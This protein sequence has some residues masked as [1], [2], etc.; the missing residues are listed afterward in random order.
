MFSYWLGLLAKKDLRSFGDGNPGGFNL[1]M[2][3]GFRFGLIG[4]LLDYMKGFVPLAFILSQRILEGPELIPVALAP[5]L[6][7]VFSP[8][9]RFKG[10]KAIAVTFGVWSAL[11]NFEA[12]VAFALVL[13]MFTIVQRFWKNG[14]Y[15]NSEWNGFA[16][17]LGLVL[18]GVYLVLRHYSYY[19]IIFWLLN[20]I[21]FVYANKRNLRIVYKSLTRSLHKNA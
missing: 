16:V 18:L 5:I 19:L 7:H 12:A 15:N 20:V 9:M 10:G 1:I 21:V 3:T 11:T 2:A 17:V 13:A 14:R 6:G 4:I 8:F